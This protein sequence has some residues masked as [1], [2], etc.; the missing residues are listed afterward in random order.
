MVT[1]EN[2]GQIAVEAIRKG[3]ADYIV[4]LGDYLF[5]I[6]VVVEKNLTIAKIQEEN[7]SLRRKLELRLGAVTGKESA[8]RGIACD[9]S[10]WQRPIRSRICITAGILAH[11]RADVCGNAAISRTTWPA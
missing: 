4:K 7:H 5:T 2:V 11:A 8:A 1:G 9:C 6:P 3:A 10:K